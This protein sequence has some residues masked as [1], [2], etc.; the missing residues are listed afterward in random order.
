MSYNDSFHRV[1]H[2]VY[3]Y[4]SHHEIVHKKR[5]GCGKCDNCNRENCGSCSACLDM[6]QYGGPGIKKK[7]CV[8]RVCP[9]KRRALD[10]L[11]QRLRDTVSRRESA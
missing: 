10:E 3:W 6:V 5:M 11:D 9:N 8:N 4:M 1:E 7:I 2:Q